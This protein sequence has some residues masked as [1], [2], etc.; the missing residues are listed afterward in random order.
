M[1]AHQSSQARMQALSRLIEAL[2]EEVVVLKGIDG[3]PPSRLANIKT[4]EAE[5]DLLEEIRKQWHDERHDKWRVVFDPMARKSPDFLTAMAMTYSLH[6]GSSFTLSNE[7]LES[8]QKYSLQIAERADGLGY[9][10]T[11]KD[12]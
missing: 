5:I 2:L 8:A 10:L 6:K 3:R 9:D 1:E 11:V 7:L 12:K 4:L